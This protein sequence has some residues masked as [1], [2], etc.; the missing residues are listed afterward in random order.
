MIDCE[1]FEILN[2]NISCEKRRQFK[3][4]AKVDKFLQVHG[5]RLF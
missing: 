2:D 4:I 3:E 5:L 1:Y